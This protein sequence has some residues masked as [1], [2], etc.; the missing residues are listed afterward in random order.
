MTS[1]GGTGYT[2]WGTANASTTIQGYAT[3][4]S[5]SADS[6]Y[7]YLRCNWQNGTTLSLSQTTTEA[8]AG[9]Y[10]ISFDA[11]TYSSN[12]TQPTYTFKVNDGASDL[13]A[14]TMTANKTSWTNY[15]DNF[16]L[17]SASTVTIT[18][19]M[20]PGAAASQRHDWMLLDN[21][22]LLY[23]ANEDAY[24]DYL[25][26]QN[27]LTDAT[28]ANPI[29]TNFVVNGT[30]DDSDISMWSCN[31]SFQNRGR[32]TTNDNNAGTMNDN[33]PWWENWNGSVLVN[34]MSQTINN[35]PN[36]TYRLDIT[37]FVNNLDAANQYVFANSDKTYLTQAG[38]GVAYEVYTVV[39][40]NTIEVGFEQTTATANWMGIDNVSL[41]YYGAGDVINAAQNASHKL[42]WDDAKAAAEAAIDDAAYVNVTGSEKS[43]LQNE[44]DKAEPTTAEGYD[45]AAAALAT[46]TQ[47]FVDAKPS[48]DAYA[49]EKAN[50]DRISTTIASG[51]T[52]P[53]IA[54]GCDAVTK[55]I[56]VGEYS[57]VAANFNADAAATYG[58]T[59]DQWTG[60][61]T[62]G[63]NSDTPQTNSGEKW[64]DAATTYYEQGRNGW[65]SNAWTLNYTKTVT[66][67][68][69]T[70]VLKVA[71][72][73][74]E[75]VTAT[76]SATIGETT[77]TE[78]LPNVGASGFGIT[79]TGVA[80]FDDADDFA[81]SDNGFGW[82]WRYLAFTLANEGEVTL[83]IDASANSSHQW[84]SFGDVAV[85]SNVSTTAME[86]AYN[87][88]TMQTLGFESGQYA[89]Y[90]NVDVLEAYAEAAAI[91]AGTRVP[92]TQAEVDAITSTLTN[93]TWTAN[94]EDVDAIYNGMFNSDVEGDWGLTGWTRTNAWGQQQTGLSGDFATAYYNQPGS[95]QYGNQGVYTMPLAANTAYKLTFSYR[96]H[97]NNS[98]KSVTVSVLNGENGLPAT[99]FAGNGSTSVWK[100]VSAYFTTESAAGNYVLTLANSGNTWITNVS[101]V[102]A[103][104][105]DALEF[106]DNAEMPIYAPGTYPTVKITRTLTENRWVTAI[107]PFA[108]SG[109]DD[110]A[111]LDSYDASTGAIGFT[112]AAS[113]TANVPFLMRSTAG[114][115]E[116]TLTNVEVAAAVASDATAGKASLKGV[117]TA[118]DIDNTD[119]NYVLSNNKIYSVGAAGATINPY[120]AYIQIDQSVEVKALN[121][122][123]DDDDATGINSLT[124]ALSEGEGAIYNVA[125]QRMSKMQKGIN[126]VNGKK[127]LF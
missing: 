35:I 126:I 99:E 101:L 79:T 27:G 92:S 117:Y 61:A 38:T 62:S 51:I 64:G 68:A 83:Q 116:I 58:I 108:V 7:F 70:Y 88:F 122:F 98:N 91:I 40:N 59:I 109:V 41:R 52:A 112:T 114:A 30:F 15:S 47:A 106:A 69:S 60:T 16:T 42:A 2:Q 93:P 96:S 36:G 12:G 87:N 48:Y 4:F 6:N 49:N 3:S 95:L 120:R 75:G 81:N 25:I 78:A 45:A 55:S 73:A 121:F 105:A 86:T 104:E 84:C 77:I 76:L 23:F 32:K 72:R 33:K 97:E 28:Y 5:P 111:V 124:P 66:L 31:T 74:S 39:T 8:A 71:A 89:P 115:P 29:V 22:K 123:I 19:A 118:T 127:V 94:T 63:G 46:A 67:P 119:K 9:R 65:G 57:Y 1:S 85:V 80:S 54:A 53:T 11:V 17:T 34:K 100:T 37:A 20:K 110:I 14:G 21:I 43:A 24:N 125:G 90:N 18:A 50:A 107:Y 44:I 10:V 102:K 113:S 13:V 56:L 103:V 26:E 82:Q